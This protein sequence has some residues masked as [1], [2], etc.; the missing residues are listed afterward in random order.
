MRPDSTLLPK[1]SR[2]RFLTHSAMVLAAPAASSLL[3]GCAGPSARDGGGL[4]AREFDTSS[5]FVRGIYLDEDGSRFF[6]A[7]SLAVLP[8][9]EQP[10][11]ETMDNHL[12]QVDTAFVAFGPVTQNEFAALLSLL[13]WAPTR[14]GVA[15]VW[16][17]WETASPA[18]VDGFLS[19]W[20][21]SSSTLLNAGYN[22]IV[23]IISTS[24]YGQPENFAKSGYPG[25]PAFAT[26]SLPQF[27]RE[28]AV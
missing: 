16:S 25:P 8:E 17:D 3:V 20:R 28:T 15:G 21:N 2:R 13:T 24:Y 6:R 27:Q 1:Q 14:M 11:A 26:S 5:P 19:D 18:E 12:R 9:L 4:Q 7:A 23:K 22:G 10:D